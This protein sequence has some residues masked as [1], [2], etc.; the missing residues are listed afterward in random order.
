MLNYLLN[1]GILL[2]YLTSLIILLSFAHFSRV[3]YLFSVVST[4]QL[5]KLYSVHESDA[6]NS[7]FSGVISFAL[8]S[9]LNYPFPV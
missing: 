8:D 7:R 5:N 9:G 2:V 4:A 3:K 1:Y 6:L